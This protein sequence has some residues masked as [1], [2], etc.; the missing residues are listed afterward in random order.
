MKRTGRL[1][2]E[3]APSVS[4]LSARASRIAADAWRRCSASKSPRQT[5][6][7]G[8]ASVV[9]APLPSSFCPTDGGSHSERAT[10]RPGSSVAHTFSDRK[11]AVHCNALPASSST[12]RA[13]S[14]RPLTAV[15]SALDSRACD[16]R[17]IMARHCTRRSSG[18]PALSLLRTEARTSERCW[19][20]A[21][22]SSSERGSRLASSIGSIR[23]T[24]PVSTA[25]RICWY[26]VAP[27]ILAA[28]GCPSASSA[29]CCAATAAASARAS[30]DPA[31][32]KTKV[33]K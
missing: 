20:S 21:S 14:E 18:S 29:R 28:C 16:V 1:A 25:A 4:V 17:A 6:R 10:S 24:S 8:N 33:R 9:V 27:V 15:P 26:I 5:R 32:G 30:G 3:P 23:C 11:L 2:L 22:P 19:H 13:A 31:S 12:L 7:M